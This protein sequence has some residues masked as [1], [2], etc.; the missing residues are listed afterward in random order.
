MQMLLPGL[1]IVGGIGLALLGAF[2]T[3]GLLSRLDTSAGR[4]A[5]DFI[6]LLALGLVPLGL[7]LGSIWYGKHRLTQDKRAEKTQ[8]DAEL[9]RRIL[10]LARAQPQGVTVGECAAETAFSTP[11][12]E[13]KLSHL[14]INGALDMEVSEQGLLLYKLKALP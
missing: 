12:V 14:Y 11:E 4:F 2:Y 1:F 7:G 13:T 3:T 9:E 6:G 10:Q 8:R 5:V